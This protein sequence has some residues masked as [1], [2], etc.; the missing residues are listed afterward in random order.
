MFS[1]IW[2]WIEILSSQFFPVRWWPARH[3][4][5]KN[6]HFQS[7][8]GWEGHTTVGGVGVLDVTVGVEVQPQFS[9]CWRSQDFGFSTIR[10][11]QIFPAHSSALKPYPPDAYQLAIYQRQW[12][13]RRGTNRVGF[14]LLD[15]GSGSTMSV[16]VPKF[17]W[18]IVKMGYF[19][20]NFASFKFFAPLAHRTT[21]SYGGCWI[22]Y[23]F[24]PRIGNQN[25]T[26]FTLAYSFRRSS[27]TERLWKQ[28]L[29]HIRLIG[30]RVIFN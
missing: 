25:Q 14:S 1:S 5:T 4:Q 15:S 20:S 6:V 12:E 29:R 7:D 27:C 2:V 22:S 21:E 9:I 30:L 26:N 17:G 8:K 24:L 18:M 23:D 11:E 3:W 13:Q 10:I 28:Y 16:L 19:L